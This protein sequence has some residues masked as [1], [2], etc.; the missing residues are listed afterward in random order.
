M[1]FKR[2]PVNQANSHDGRPI[3]EEDLAG[4]YAINPE[5][6]EDEDEDEQEKQAELTASIKTLIPL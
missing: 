2:V 5:A 1:L 4:I 3:N 6:L